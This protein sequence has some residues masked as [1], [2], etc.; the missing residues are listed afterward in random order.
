MFEFPSGVESRD[1]QKY[2][3]ESRGIREERMTLL[4][5][6]SSNLPDPTRPSGVLSP[7]VC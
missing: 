3:R 1:T 5:R 6:A 7:E 2:D 4:L